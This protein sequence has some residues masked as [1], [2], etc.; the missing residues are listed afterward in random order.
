[1]KYLSF[2]FFS[3][4][5][6]GSVIQTRSLWFRCYLGCSNESSWCKLSCSLETHLSYASRKKNKNV[7]LKKR[8]S[9]AV[10][11]TVYLAMDWKLFHVSS[12]IEDNDAVMLIIDLLGTPIC[13]C[14]AIR[15]SAPAR[16]FSAEEGL[17]SYTHS[18]PCIGQ[19]SIHTGHRLCDLFEAFYR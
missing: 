5:H 18:P 15:S 13:K 14:T 3:C 7:P 16:T 1:M 6:I 2:W 9:R 10:K 4:F 11:G 17:P 12:L 8:C 19:E